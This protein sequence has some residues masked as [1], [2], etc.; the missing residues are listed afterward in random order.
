M[1]KIQLEY[2][3]EKDLSLILEDGL[4]IQKFSNK[5]NVSERTIKSILSK[6]CSYTNQTIE[7]IYSC[8]YKEGYRLN[9]IKEEILKETSK[10]IILFHG[11]KYGI[12]EILPSGSRETCDF[13][14]GFYLGETFSQAISFVF[15]FK[16]SCVYSFRSNLENLKIYRFECSLEWLLAVCYYRGY[17]KQYINNGIITKL[18]NSIETSDLII[19]P[20]AD[21]RMFFIMQQF[22]D[23][24][25]TS[26]VAIHSLSASSLGY[27][28]VLKSDKA[29]DKLIP[30]ER[31]YLCEYEKESSSIDL[32]KRGD[33]IETKLKIS[34]R[35]FR[36]KGKYID[37]LF[38]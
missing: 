9:S 36:N 1:K 12:N 30:I 34:K 3:I 5:S 35:E 4:T 26:E 8:I 13:G 19:A 16:Q 23:G 28:Y 32:L 21:N 18:I 29:I 38:N 15:D 24:E 22:A 33:Q 17:I 37:E 7:K 10:D 11:S 14:K 31:H 6:E 20:I 2:L 25:I 27:Q